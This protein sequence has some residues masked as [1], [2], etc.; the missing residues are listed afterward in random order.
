MS[1]SEELPVEGTQTV[2]PDA[3]I[4]DIDPPS[5]PTSGARRTPARNEPLRRVT[6]PGQQRTPI[7]RGEERSQHQYQQDPENV[8]HRLSD[9]RFVRA[10][11][12]SFKLAPNLATSIGNGGDP[13]RRDPALE[14]HV[15]TPSATPDAERDATVHLDTTCDFFPARRLGYEPV[16]RLAA[17]SGRFLSHAGHLLTTCDAPRLVSR[18]RLL[19]LS[20]SIRR[21][22]LREPHRLSHLAAKQVGGAYALS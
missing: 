15:L 8:L 22:P 1:P 2:E 18:R 9:V 4:R 13:S 21:C 12:V 19:I 14:G 20:S 11:Q 3:R 6:L 17:A 10:R 5:L 16:E 7:W